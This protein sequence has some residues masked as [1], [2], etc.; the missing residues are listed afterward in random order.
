MRRGLED[1]KVATAV[2]ENWQPPAAAGGERGF[3]LELLEGQNSC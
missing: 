2:E 3:S 1:G